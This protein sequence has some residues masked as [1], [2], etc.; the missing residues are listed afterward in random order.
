MEA[1]AANNDPYTY[2]SWFA[3]MQG[4]L[5]IVYPIVQKENGLSVLFLVHTKLHLIHFT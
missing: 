4:T 5:S 3:A 1:E 2:W